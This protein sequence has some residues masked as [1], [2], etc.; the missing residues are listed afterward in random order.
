MLMLEGLSIDDIARRLRASHGLTG[1]RTRKVAKQIAEEW[2][3]HPI[4][5]VT[6]IRERQRRRVEKW[7]DQLTWQLKPMIDA[8]GK[9]VLDSHGRQIMVPDSSKIPWASVA[10]F[11]ALLG[12]ITGTTRPIEVHHSGMVGV[13]VAGV[14]SSLTE[15]EARELVEEQLV[16][17]RKAQLAEKYGITEEVAAKLTVVK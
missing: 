5:N 3:N 17:E 15:E 12:N 11:E 8:Y 9:P 7:L 13:A 10:K 14:I 2:Q 16:V 4:E 1:T 6:E